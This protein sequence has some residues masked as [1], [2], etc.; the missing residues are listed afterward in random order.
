MADQ[1]SVKSVEHLKMERTMA[2]RAF[3]RLAN[4][5]MRTY[6][7]MSEDDLRESFNRLTKAAERVLETNDDLEAKF[8]A[9]QEGALGPGK[10]VALTEQQ[11]AELTKTSK[12]CE[13]RLKEV[14]DAIQMALWSNFGDTEF[15]TAIRAAERESQ[16][17]GDVQ[18]SGGLAA[19]DFMLTHLQQLIKTAKEAYNKW[20]R[21]IPSD[22]QKDT[23]NR[24]KELE[25][26]LPS[27]VSRKADFIQVKLREE[28][29]RPALAPVS[30]CPMPAIRLKPIA[31]PKFAGVKRDFHRWRKDWEAMQ[32][33]GEPTGSKEVKKFQL[34]DSLDERITQGLRLT[35]YNSAEDIFRVLENRY[36]NKVSIAIEIVEELQEMP[37]V[38]DHQPRR[39][40]ELIQAVEKALQDLSDLGDTGAIKNPLV[41]KSI[42][43]KLPETLKKDW[44]VYAADG[45]NAVATSNRFDCLLTFLKEQEHIYEQ[46]D[47]LRDEPSRSF[48]PRPEPRHARTRATE[49]GDDHEGCVVCGD[50]RHRKKLFFCKQFK[51]L[52]LVDKKAAVRE[53]GACEKCL[54]IH[55]TGIFCKPTYL[56]RHQNCE[57]ECAAAHH[58][59]LCPNEEFRK[60][61]AVQRAARRGLEPREQKEYTS[62]QEEFLSTLPP[63]LAE[64]CRNV[65]SNT[66]SKTLSTVMG[67]PSLLMENGPQE[68][69]VIM[70]LLEVTVNCG[71]RIG[72]LID[73]ASDTNYITHSA[74]SRL[75]LKS[76]DVSLIVHGV[77]GMR[78]QLKTKRYLL[79]I[80]VKTPKGALRSHQLVCYGLDSIA[81]V[82]RDVSAKR[83]QRFFPSVPV[84]ELV[85]P[86][87]VSLLIS[88]REGKLA[89]QRIQVIEDLVLWDGPLGKTVGGSH[90]DLFE[91]GDVLPRG[92]K[93]H[94]ARSMR[95]ATIACQEQGLQVAREGLVCG[96]GN[97]YSVRKP[98]DNSQSFEVECLSDMWTDSDVFK[99]WV[100]SDQSGRKKSDGG[101]DIEESAATEVIVTPSKIDKDT[102]WQKGSMEKWPIRLAKGAVSFIRESVN[103]LQEKASIAAPIRSE[104]QKQEPAQDQNQVKTGLGTATRGLVDIEQPTNLTRI[105]RAV[106]WIWG[107]VERPSSLRQNVHRAKWEVGFPAVAQR[108]AAFLG[109][110]TWLKASDK[111]AVGAAGNSAVPSCCLPVTKAPKVTVSHGSYDLSFKIQPTILHWDVQQVIV[112]LPWRELI[113]PG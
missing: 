100:S 2:K 21:W 34:L 18:L 42:E 99:K 39:I 91:E 52:R 88:H 44:L 31:L 32:R 62:K 37:A 51:S 77:G 81:D 6:E 14:K 111:C 58:Y 70:M 85:R 110:A 9:D 40:V 22:E 96:S 46:L 71:Q 50:V 16:R 4:S 107:A 25:L 45:R 64:Q 26:T 105:I 55:N 61:N 30:I 24:I 56:C 60:S 79:R 53:L 5:V 17:V 76:E 43:S 104:V 106:T 89:P 54:E 94:F 82:H 33:Q 87:E 49:L 29:E 68:L 15:S 95:V 35:A 93:T 63:D 112:L 28:A 59:F 101:M 66:A 80:Q 57:D 113:Q 8:I 78:V 83:L 90:P 12:D 97:Q 38:K 109:R 65:F 10:V 74:A 3:S 84:K 19:Y 36:G 108:I 86:K 92:S 41:T 103:K 11:K 1:T 102:E 73:L 27:L 20:K 72:T 47:Q 69:P 75:N 13:L 67:Q 23:Q 48:L 98:C 7:D